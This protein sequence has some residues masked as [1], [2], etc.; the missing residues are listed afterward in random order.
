MPGPH[1]ARKALGDKRLRVFVRRPRR[2][3]PAVGVAAGRHPFGTVRRLQPGFPCW[4][5]CRRG[6]A[7]CRWAAASG[8]GPLA[9]HGAGI[10]HKVSYSF[11]EKGGSVLPMTNP[12]SARVVCLHGFTGAPESWDDVVAELAADV[13]RPPLLG[14]DPGDAIGSRSFEDEV[15]RLA[16]RFRERGRSGLQLA[17]Y[18]LG[19]RLAVGLLARHR[20]LFAS[21]TLIGASPGLASEDARRRRRADDERLARLLE[22]EGLER[23]LEHW[24]ALPLFAS[25]RRQPEARLAAQRALRL[26][27]RPAALARAL[28]VLGLGA[29]P[30]YRSALPR[31]DVP[32]HLM[33]GELDAKFTELARQM[34]ALL[35]RADVE[36]VPGAGHNLPLEAP[37]QVAAAI[38]RMC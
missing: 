8:P 29:M 18:S 5:A 31:I 12:I 14:H 4:K 13:D 28:R 3:R 25:Q 27:H 6:A 15:D 20:E 32:V 37:R 36:I 34:A 11:P 30:D 21:A 17:G 2:R 24:E 33:A 38:R 10:P 16:R 7:G 26:R 23:F 35:P 22:D 19:G 9:A 1:G